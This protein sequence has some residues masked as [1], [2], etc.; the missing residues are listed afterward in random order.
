MLRT[1]GFPTGSPWGT[2]RGRP[3][4]RERGA[5]PRRTLHAW[6]E[7]QFPTYGWLAFEPTPERTNP[8]AQAYLSP[9]SEGC[10][11]RKLPGR[12]AAVG[13]Q[14]L[15]ARSGPA[16]P[17]RGSPNGTLGIA[18]TAVPARPGR[19]E[20][21]FPTGR[22]LLGLTALALLGAVL[23]P[24]AKLLRRRLRLALGRAPTRGSSCSRPTTCSPSGRPISDPGDR[25]ARRCASTASDCEPARAPR[26]ETWSG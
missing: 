14:G 24:P 12:R 2:P 23:V 11:G 5:S 20:R 21:R 3:M 6:V 22:V 8:I 13:R 15:G 25:R 19:R 4:A 16:V 26:T 10:T 9:T 7:V 17:G 18:A 1:L